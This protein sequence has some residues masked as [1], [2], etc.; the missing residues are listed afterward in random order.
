V[1]RSQEDTCL[2]CCGF[3]LGKVSGPVPSAGPLTF[4]FAGGAVPLPHPPPKGH[5]NLL[6]PAFQVMVGP[7]ERENFLSSQGSG[8]SRWVLIFSP[9]C[10][11]CLI[12]Y[13]PLT[14][15]SSSRH[16]HLTNSHS[17]SS[18]PLR[19]VLALQELGMRPRDLC[20]SST[21]P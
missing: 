3:G 9:S 8:V 13:T 12:K 18:I 16:F 19:R 6:Y 7:A 14:L 11:K 21:A 17:L 5:F 4:P 1:P 10:R 15:F 20:F 2:K